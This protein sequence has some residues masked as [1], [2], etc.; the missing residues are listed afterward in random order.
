M[1]HAH[2]GLTKSLFNDGIALDTAVYSSSQYNRLI[3]SFKVALTSPSSVIVVTGP[4]GVG[5]TT[6]TSTALRASTTR[7]AI[8]WLNGTPTNASELLELLLIELGIA[9]LRTSRIER[10]Q[11]WRQFQSEMSATASRLFV[12]AERTEDLSPEVLRA[13]DSL[14][15]PDASGNPGANVVLLGQP[16]LERHLGQP[17]LDA[18]RQRIRL[19]AQLEPFTEAE[20]QDYLRHQVACAGGRFEAL[21]APGV[22][23]M[24]Y[25][26]SGGVAR[27]A[28]NL[29]ETALTLA[30]T[31]LEKTLTVATLTNAAAML[32]LEESTPVLAAAAA[33]TKTP[34]SVQPAVRAEPISPMPA[35]ATSRSEAAAAPRVA[36]P[37]T[38]PTSTAPPAFS[39][40]PSAPPAPARQLLMPAATPTATAPTAPPAVVAPPPPAPRT[41]AVEFEFDGEATDI[42]DVSL[43]DFP[44]LTDAVDPEPVAPAPQRAVA[45]PPAPVKPAAVTPPSVAAPIMPAP[46][47]P[48]AAVVTP[49]AAAATPPPAKR[50]ET[51]YS[52]PKAA[53]PPRPATPAPALPPKPAAPP[54]VA[55]AA[56]LAASAAAPPAAKP[57]AAPSPPK[58]P[59]AEDEDLARQT[60]TMRAISVAK[61]ID[62]LNDSMAETLFGDAE[63]DLMTAAL[64]S[65]ANWDDDKPGLSAATPVAPA[66]PTAAAPT[67]TAA[68]PAPKPAAKPSAPAKPAASSGDD[69]LDLLGLSDAPLELIDDSTLPPT[70]P[71]AAGQR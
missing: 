10:L 33:T 32:G 30:A 55:P 18:L 17:S 16:G 69:L 27:L 45:P 29:C 14:T 46:V 57:A 6:L 13:L 48:A 53:T 8:A 5:K 49:A 64:A 65:S 54:A 37:P 42:P 3:A 60:Q 71:K 24:L 40:K 44:I 56:P 31:Q 41:A 51:A 12:V 21:F 59:A 50:V 38:T 70:A 66:K 7:L 19:K 39:V 15:T 34:P 2:F 4:A 26:H 36:P 58:K 28:N 35:P 62:D 61:S 43:S 47:R 67:K 20:L 68:P 9:T 25:R 11:L 63:L 1:Y 22:V 23:A 52:P